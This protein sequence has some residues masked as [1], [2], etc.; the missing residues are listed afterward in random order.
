MALVL[1]AMFVCGASVG[2][3]AIQA[4]VIRPAL[5]NSTNRI[6]D[7]WPAA[8]AV[9]A[10]AAMGTSFGYFLTRRR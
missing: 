9:V 1:V 7:S 3:F 10:L 6:P 8:V 2:L 5:Y 4:E